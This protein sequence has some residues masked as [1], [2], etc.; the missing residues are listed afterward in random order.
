[1]KARNSFQPVLP[2]VSVDAWVGD[3]VVDAV[4]NVVL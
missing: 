1:M 4:D 3:A 2:E